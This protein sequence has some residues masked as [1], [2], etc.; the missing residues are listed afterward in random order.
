M[1]MLSPH[2]TNNNEMKEMQS[3]AIFTKRESSILIVLGQS[4]NVEY[5]GGG[6]DRVSS[7]SSLLLAHHPHSESPLPPVETHGP[8]DEVEHHEHDGE[9]HQ[10]HIIH[11]GPVKKVGSMQ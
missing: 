6:D 11:L 4:I 2:G 1:A 10:E 3:V 5:G 7:M 8:V 9:H